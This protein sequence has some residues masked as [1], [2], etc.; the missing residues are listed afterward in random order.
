MNHPPF[1]FSAWRDIG[2]Y[3]TDLMLDVKCLPDLATI[4]NQHFRCVHQTEL[5]WEHKG[6]LSQSLG[7]LCLYRILQLD[8]MQC[9]LYCTN[10]GLDVLSYS[11]ISQLLYAKENL[12]ALPQF[13]VQ[14]QFHFLAVVLKCLWLWPS[15]TSPV[16]GLTHVLNSQSQCLVL[17]ASLCRILLRVWHTSFVT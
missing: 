12:T 4:R 13:P 1:G 5:S 15:G 14:V 3:V 2:A 10:G 16:L 8:L 9:M 17:H 6:L 7:Y 11:T